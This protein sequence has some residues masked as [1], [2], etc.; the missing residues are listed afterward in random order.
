MKYLISSIKDLDKWFAM[1]KGKMTDKTP[2][3]EVTTSPHKEDKTD[4][5]R[6]YVHTIIKEHLTP[7]L[8]EYG[9][10]EANSEHLAKE[11][12]KEYC[13]YGELKTFKFKGVA[14]ERFVSGSFSN[15]KKE[16]LSEII[17]AIVRICA[18]VDVIVTK[19]D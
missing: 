10:I 5:Q 2:T 14:R 18:T 19:G 1:V 16:P 9:N 12:I 7:V 15:I 4:P 17:E 11:W 6:K 13:G 8:F 3:F